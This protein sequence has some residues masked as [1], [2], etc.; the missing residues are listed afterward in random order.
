MVR[1]FSQGNG[2]KVAKGCFSGCPI[3]N[4]LGSVFAKFLDKSYFVLSSN[5]TISAPKRLKHKELSKML[6]E[7]G[8][9]GENPGVRMPGGFLKMERGLKSWIGDS[10]WG[11][12]RDDEVG[13]CV[14]GQLS[15]WKM[16]DIFGGSAPLFV[17]K[18][19]LGKK[20]T[21]AF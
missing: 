11:A 6:S 14:F 7:F 21:S 3:Q 8:G 4:F 12:P 5:A 1:A 20:G 17:G 15:F 9:F 13:F 10:H 18:G 19:G 2:G 16:K